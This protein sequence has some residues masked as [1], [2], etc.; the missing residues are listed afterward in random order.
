MIHNAVDIPVW[1]GSPVYAP[2][3]GVVYVTK[4]NGYGYS[5]I[6]MSHACGFNTTYGHMSEILVEEG[7][8][9]EKGTIIGL[10]GGM[11]GTLGAGYMTTGPHLHYEMRL[12]GM[13]VDPMNHLP[14]EV[15]EEGELIEKYQESWE[16]AVLRSTFE[17]IER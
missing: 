5:Y 1:Q 17:A 15:F 4:E 16:S 6:I 11:P 14:L 3:E 10:S 2:A 9:L 8:Y 13:Y 7:Q 12:N